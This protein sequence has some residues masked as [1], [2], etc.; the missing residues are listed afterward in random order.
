MIFINAKK[1]IYQDDVWAT[2]NIEASFS[3]KMLSTINADMPIWDHYVVRNLCLNMKG[4][5]KEDQLNCGVNLYDQII[6]WYKEFLQTEN[7]SDCIA[8]F[9][10]S[11]PGYVWMIDVKKID[12]YLWSIRD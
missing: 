3:S 9:N 12:F 10:R 5:T 8:E 1:V 4:K 2:G 7:G 6:K 11:L